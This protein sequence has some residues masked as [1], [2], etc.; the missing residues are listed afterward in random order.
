M[1]PKQARDDP[2]SCLGQAF[3][4]SPHDDPFVMPDLIRYLRTLLPPLHFLTLGA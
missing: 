4:T 3:G 1:T 2:G